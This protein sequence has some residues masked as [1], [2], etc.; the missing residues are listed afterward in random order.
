MKH[1]LINISDKFYNLG[2]IV[3]LGLKSGVKMGEQ[4]TL[5]GQGD[6]GQAKNLVFSH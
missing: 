5:Q 2:S 3:G 6:L 4:W 1:F